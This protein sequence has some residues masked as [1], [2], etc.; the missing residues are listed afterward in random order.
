MDFVLV[1]A[2]ARD[3]ILHHV[4]GAPV[5]RATLDVDIALQ[6]SD[7]AAFHAVRDTLIAQGYSAT[8]AD[9]RLLP[10]AG[11]CIDIIPFGGIAN[12]KGQ[13]AWPPTGL[14]EMTV[15]GFEES[16]R[17]ACRIEFDD[18]PDLVLPVASLE[19][20]TIMKLIAWSERD[21]A[22]RR[23]DAA[24]IAYILSNYHLVDADR[25]T[26]F[27]PKWQ[28][29]MERHG[30]DLQI[31]SAHLLGHRIRQI[32]QRETLSALVTLLDDGIAHR[33]VEVLL[34][35]MRRSDSANDYPALF[36]ALED[37]LRDR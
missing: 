24:D 5:R 17:S 28:F 14:I 12:D 4:Y 15:T 18:E 7:W 32:A 35:E 2:K 23:K 25:G 22:E 1:G 19:G 21:P 36:E 11:G 20:M 31:T 10:A 26:P 8:A 13:I 9:H 3:L 34:L 29:L 27:E 37:G 16:Y 6:V 33:N 30:Y